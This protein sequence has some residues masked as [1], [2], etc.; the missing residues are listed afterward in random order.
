MFKYLVVAVDDGR[1]ALS[2]MEVTEAVEGTDV[3]IVTFHI[4]RPRVLL[5][6]F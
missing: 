4:E 2:V 6:L 3:K 5:L 1:F